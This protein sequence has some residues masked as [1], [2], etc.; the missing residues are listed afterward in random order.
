MV[1]Q[2]VGQPVGQPVPS[3]VVDRNMLGVEGRNL[4]EGVERPWV[5]SGVLGLGWRILVVV[6]GCIVECVEARTVVEVEVRIVVV[7]VGGHIVVEEGA[8]TVVGV[9]GDHSAV[10]R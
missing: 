2:L 4:V 8:R 7:E 5:D 9:V 10:W 6:V 3:L 1:G